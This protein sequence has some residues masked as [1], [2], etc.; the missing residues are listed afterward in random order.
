M[1]RPLRLGP[2][3]SQLLA[4]LSQG[5]SLQGGPLLPPW[6][7]AS[8][9]SLTNETYTLHQLHLILS[10]PGSTLGSEGSQK[11]EAQGCASTPGP[12]GDRMCLRA[13]GMFRAVP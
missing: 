6:P 10:A 13:K 3:L 4:S 8:Y 1:P 7:L 12:G 5:N 9:T 11:E 2:S